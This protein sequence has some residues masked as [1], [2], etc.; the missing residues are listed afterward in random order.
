[1]KAIRTKPKMEEIKEVVTPEVPTEPTVPSNEAI[2]AEKD[3]EIAKLQKKEVELQAQKE[4]WREKYER[5]VKPEPEPIVS[6]DYS[7]EGKL[8]RA[9]IKATNERIEAF[10]RKES[11]REAESKYP[12]LKERKEDFDTFLENEEVKNLS[13]DK[14]STLFLAENGL[15]G[16]QTPRKGLEKPTGG[17]VTPPKQGYSDEEL[18]EMR[19]KNWRKYEGLIKAGKV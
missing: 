15:L 16:G 17:S 7:E 6:E 2:L 19:V 18:E 13:L 4:H 1:M 12:I 8:L 5:D 3:A 11:R 14:A 10:E 9:E